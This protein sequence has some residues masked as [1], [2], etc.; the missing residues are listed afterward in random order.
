MPISLLADDEPPAVTETRRDGRSDFVILVDHASRLIPRSLGTLGL[1]ESDLARH[2]AWDIGSLAVARL[3]SEALDATLIHQN[4]SRLVIDC[5]RDPMTATSIPEI[6][7]TTPIPG[8]L[9]LRQS[10]R[11]PRI[12]AIF[13]PY[14]QRIAALLDERERQGRR[15]ILIAQHTMTD[16]FKGERRAMQSAVMYNRDPRFARR[17]RQALADETG[18]TVA[19]NQPYAMTDATDYTL[20]LHGEKR[21]LPHVG[22]EV[23]QDLVAD[24]AGQAEWAARIAA[25]LETARREF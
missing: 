22:L 10:E 13:T 23:R 21:G 24:E 2:I 8:N 12:D 17:L 15:T 19:D 11:Q 1:S 7:E 9:C 14:H 20:P 5:N 6:G 18:L 3:V 4:Y 25:A 16:L